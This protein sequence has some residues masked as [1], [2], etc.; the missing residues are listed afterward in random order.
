[1]VGVLVDDDVYVELIGQACW[2][3]EKGYS[4][5]IDEYEA[6]SVNNSPCKKIKINK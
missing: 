4:V 3:N 1:M 5:K 2:S 6:N